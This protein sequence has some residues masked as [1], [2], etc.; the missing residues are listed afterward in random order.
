[1]RSLMAIITALVCSS[2]SI[3]HEFWW[4]GDSTTTSWMPPAEAWV[5]TGPRLV[6]TNGALPSKAG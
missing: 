2:L 4:F 3:D 1:M 5:N 6:T